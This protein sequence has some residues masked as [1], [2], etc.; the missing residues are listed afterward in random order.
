MSATIPLGTKAAMTVR[1]TTMRRVEPRA[2][3]R[4][5]YCKMDQSLQGATLHVEHILP[6][7]RGGSSR[8]ENLARACPSCN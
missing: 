1:S 5:E 4:C 6:G 8:L 7:S 2:N 3:G